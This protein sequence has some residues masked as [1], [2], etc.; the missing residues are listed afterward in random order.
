MSWWAE[1]FLSWSRVGYL[2]LFR[3]SSGSRR[4]RLRVAQV[5]FLVPKWK[6]ICL[7]LSRWTFLPLLTTYTYIRAVVSNDAS[8]VYALLS[9]CPIITHRCI[10]RTLSTITS[11]LIKLPNPCLTIRLHDLYSFTRKLVSSSDVHLMD[12]F[13]DGDVLHGWFHRWNNGWSSCIW[14]VCV[15]IPFLP[16]I[17]SDN[18]LFVCSFLNTSTPFKNCTINCRLV[19]YMLSLRSNLHFA[20]WTKATNFLKTATHA[21]IDFGP[22]DLSG[23]GLLTVRNLDGHGVRVI[24]V[25]EKGNGDAELFDIKY[26]A[27]W[28]KNRWSPGLVQTRW[29]VVA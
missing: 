12:T 14:W 5:G 13:S 8:A 24:V 4:E 19:Y 1:L 21:S 26:E 2:T 10:M 17:A 27:C 22:D 7:W 9:S 28:L 25:G 23:I 3:Y 11:M 6:F 29:F 18:L 16:G 15:S 20:H